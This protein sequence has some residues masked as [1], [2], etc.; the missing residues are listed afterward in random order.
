MK[1]IENET[2]NIALNL[3]QQSLLGIKVDHN[4]LYYILKDLRSLTKPPME[5]QELLEAVIIII[6]SPSADLSW[7]KGAKRLM[8][9]VDRFKEMLMEFPSHQDVSESLLESLQPYIVRPRF[10]EESL[11]H[12][13]LAASQ[14]CSWV[15]GVE[16]L[17]FD[18]ICIINNYYQMY[19]AIIE[20]FKK[21]YV[22]WSIENLMLKLH[23]KST[24]RN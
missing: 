16:R 3:D 24:Q 18:S 21:I 5:L 19:I 11:G 4:C 17:V 23:S 9:N 1:H 15:R 7:A 20:C 12:M 10:N 14:L 8:A 22:D 13:Y 2:K 6:K